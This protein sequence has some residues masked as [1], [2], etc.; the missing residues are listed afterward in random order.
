L[1]RNGEDRVKKMLI[2]GGATL[3]ESPGE[4]AG[5]WKLLG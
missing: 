2:P 4:F 5:A 1:Q 3:N